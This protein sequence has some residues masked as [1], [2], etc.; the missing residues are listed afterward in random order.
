MAADLIL[1]EQRNPLD[2]HA[3]LHFTERRG[4]FQS[5]RRTDEARTIRTKRSS[6]TRRP[7][8]FV[9]VTLTHSAISL[10]AL[11]RCGETQE[12]ISHYYQALKD[13]RDDRYAMNNLALIVQPAHKRASQRRRGG[14]VGPTAVDCRTAGSPRSPARWPRPTPRPAVSPRPCKLPARPSLSEATEQPGSRKRPK[15]PCD[16]TWPKS[17]TASRPQNHNPPADVEEF[18]CTV[19]Q[20]AITPIAPSLWYNRIV[21][22]ALRS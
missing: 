22:V 17:P 3:A 12:A 20:L 16:S 10:F 5:R 11:A 21:V 15:K 4:P 1:A 9:P 8:E 7:C 2:P 14:R 13:D 18:R 6:T 19:E